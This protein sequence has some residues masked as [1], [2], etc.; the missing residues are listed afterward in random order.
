MQSEVHRQYGS[1][2]SYG[3]CPECDQLIIVL[4]SG[5]YFEHTQ[6]DEDSRE[7]N[8]PV[9]REIVYPIGDRTRAA[10]TEVPTAYVNDFKE[11]VEVLP[12]S[13][14]ASAAMSRRLLQK[15]LQEEHKIKHNSLAREI[16][17]FI[18]MP[19][20]PSYIAEAVDAVR[21]IGNFA[22]HPQKDTR[23][24]EIVEVEAGE[25]EWLLDV[26]E[27]LFDFTFVQPLRLKQR[28]AKLNAKLSALGKPPMKP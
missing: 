9:S 25:A 22:A 8:G 15:M 6:D 26:V 10:P 5:S 18:K 27:A 23:T 2:I 20:L 1:R 12:V 14:K 11:A 17:D 4:E 24:G 28:R 13:R 21:N 7:F 19:G 16:D 3:F